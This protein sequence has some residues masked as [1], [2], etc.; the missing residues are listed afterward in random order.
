MQGAQLV[1]ESIS[2]EVWIALLSHTPTHTHTLRVHHDLS[3]RQ[4]SQSSF[5][6][7]AEEAA[8]GRLDAFLLGLLV[9]GVLAAGNA[10]EGA[11]VSLQGGHDAAD[12]KHQFLL[13]STKSKRREK[14]ICFPRKFGK[15]ISNQQIHYLSFGSI[16]S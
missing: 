7:L 2:T 1:G 12:D 11:G 10:A 6:L 3:V 15:N 13:K 14:N 9:Q 16:P 4:V 8:D 5:L